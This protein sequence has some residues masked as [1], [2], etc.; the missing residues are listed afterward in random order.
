ML[1]QSK[2]KQTTS[3]YNLYQCFTKHINTIGHYGKVNIFSVLRN[4]IIV[5]RSFFNFWFN[6]VSL[7]M[8][9]FTLEYILAMALIINLKHIITYI[10]L[11]FIKNR[12]PHKTLSQNQKKKRLSYRKRW[13]YCRKKKE[14]DGCI[15]SQKDFPVKYI[16]NI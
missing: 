3:Y 7:T 13:F 8:D 12:S 10:Y 4:L 1:Y 9:L 15:M 11:L 6:W 14:E 16:V 5:T 2:S